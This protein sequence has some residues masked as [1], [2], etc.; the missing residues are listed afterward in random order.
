MAKEEP[1]KSEQDEELTKQAEPA[2]DNGEVKENSADSGDAGDDEFVALKKALE[3]AEQ[4]AEE[5]W[6]NM[7]RMR[8]EL[9]NVT[10]RST[11]D[12]EKARKFAIEKFAEDLLPVLDSLELGL[13]A[14]NAGAT[15]VSKVREGVELT[16]KMFQD[17]VVKYGITIV[18]PEGQRFDPQFHQAMTM[19]PS[20]DVEPNHVITVFQKGY[21]LNE[22]LIRPARVVVAQKAEGA[23]SQD[24]GKDDDGPVGGSIDEMA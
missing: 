22:R 5:S 7:L 6:S 18:D 24:K 11:R 1:M 9:E 4:K 19:Q 10:R 2:M 13:D 12:Q 17:T 23:A 8:A 15:D 3:E 20:V 16:L 14:A 21:V